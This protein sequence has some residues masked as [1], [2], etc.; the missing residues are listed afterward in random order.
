MWIPAQSRCRR[1]DAVEWF[2]ALEDTSDVHPV[3]GVWHVRCRH[4]RSRKPE[5]S[6]PKSQALELQGGI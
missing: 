6:E 3:L 4:S 5:E 2:D 1:V